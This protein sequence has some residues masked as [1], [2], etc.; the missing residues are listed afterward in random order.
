MAVIH[1]N[2]GFHGTYQ[3]GNQILEIAHDRIQPYDMTYGAAGACFYSTFLGILREHGL[4]VDRAD[5]EV[6][7]RKRSTIPSTLE[8]LKLRLHLEA[9]DNREVLETCMQEALEKCSMLATI[10]S[11]AEIDAEIVYE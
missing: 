11:V 1:F 10:R 8:Y 9:E 7:G 2:N 3:I 6:E 4:T 5:V